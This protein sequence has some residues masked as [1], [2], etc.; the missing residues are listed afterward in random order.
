MLFIS[1]YKYRL[2]FRF[3]QSWN[4]VFETLILHIFLIVR[5]ITRIQMHACFSR[6]SMFPTQDGFFEHRWVRIVFVVGDDSAHDVSRYEDGFNDD[7]I[8]G[9][10]VV[11]G[12]Q[13]DGSVESRWSEMRGKTLLHDRVLQQL[14]QKLQTVFVH[15]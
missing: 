1:N 8:V 7:D 5:F 10:V 12:G 3:L 4:I 9:R 11:D 6:T 14:R 2:M 13:H 15:L